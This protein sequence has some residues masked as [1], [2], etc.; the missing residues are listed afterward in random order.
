MK[1][2]TKL[3]ITLFGIIA[4][5]AVM[6]VSFA[7]CG[8]GDD[9]GG[10][11]PPGITVPKPGNLPAFPADSRP[12]TTEQEADAVLAHV[13]AWSVWDI[14]ESFADSITESSPDRHNYN[15]TNKKDDDGIVTVSTSMKSNENMS[16]NYEK[17]RNDD[18]NVTLT[19]SDYFRGSYEMKIKGK[20]IVN[21][22]GII[23]GS[24]VEQQG[25]RSDSLSVLEAGPAE[26]ARIRHSYSEKIQ[27]AVGG[28]RRR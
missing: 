15:F 24:T 9:S 28:L 3:F 1:N 6:V 5:S 22:H 11:P 13:W 16:K 14:M 8:G 26:T 10:G 23:A 18:D 21:Y 19:T 7:A 25:N 17:Y 12:A 2:V 27:Y 4:V 20:T